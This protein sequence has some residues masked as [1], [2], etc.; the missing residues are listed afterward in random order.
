MTRDST[1]KKFSTED[2][3]LSFTYFTIMKL[4]MDAL[5]RKESRNFLDDLSNLRIE[6]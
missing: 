3:T 2:S 5:K 6:R 4:I 1:I